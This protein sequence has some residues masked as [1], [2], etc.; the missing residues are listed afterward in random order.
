MRKDIAERI[1]NLNGID[2][3]LYPPFKAFESSVIQQINLLEQPIIICV[4]LVVRELSNAVRFCTQQVCTWKKIN[5]RNVTIFF[6]KVILRH[7][8]FYRWHS[9]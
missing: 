6:R 2:V 5:N 3:G 8:L 9:L 1:E 7:F 4:D